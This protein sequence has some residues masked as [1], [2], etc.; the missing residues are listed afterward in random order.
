M[1]FKVYFK[2]SHRLKGNWSLRRRQKASTPLHCITHPSLSLR[3]ALQLWHNLHFYVTYHRERELARAHISLKCPFLAIHAK[4]GESINPKKKD[5]TTH[6]FQ[7][8]VLR[9]HFS[10][11]DFSIWYLIFDRIS[12]WYNPFKTNI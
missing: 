8:F 5:C 12:N 3:T 6:Q 2:P 7:K 9:K 10:N 11:G 4:G 1:C